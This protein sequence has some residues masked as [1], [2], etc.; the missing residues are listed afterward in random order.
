[1]AIG[2]PREADQVCE[3]LITAIYIV[4]GIESRR[5]VGYMEQVTTV[6]SWGG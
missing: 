6:I 1:M 2:C 3:T 5:V 4:H